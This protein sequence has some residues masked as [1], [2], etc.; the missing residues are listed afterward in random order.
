[1]SASNF[2]AMQVFEGPVS[3]EKVSA[4][5]QALTRSRNDRVRVLRALDSEFEVLCECGRASCRDALVVTRD[6]YEEIRRVPGYLL[7]KNG[8]GGP[9]DCIVE[10]HGHVVVIE[11][12]GRREPDAGEPDQ[13]PQ[14]LASGSG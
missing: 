13:D 11:K 9:P 5:R 6:L 3:S 8:H 4:G 10:L 2:D 12:Y 7:V 1:M 14:P